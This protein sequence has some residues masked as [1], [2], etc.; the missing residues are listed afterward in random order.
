MQLH[1]FQRN[2]VSNSA[3]FKII[4]AGRRSG[5]STF[6]LEEMCYTAVTGKD[7][8]IFYICPTMVQAR[9]IIWEALKS[10]LGGIGETNEARL[11][12]KVPTTDGGY[13][14]I[15]VSGFESRENFRGLKAHL[16]VFDEL[17]TMRDFFIGWQEIFR[18]ALTDTAGR[19]IFIGTPKKENPNL[20]RLEKIAEVDKDYAFFQFR[21]EDNPFIPKEEIEKARQELDYST[22]RQEFLAEYVENQGSL[23]KYDALVDVFSNTITKE[24]AKYLTVDI[25]DDGTDKT[26]FSFWEGLEEYRRE[27]F[28]RLNTEG[29]IQ[30]IREYAAQE[31]I[32]YSNIAVDA[33]GVGAGVASSSQLDG[34]IG[35]KS[36]FAPIKTDLDPTRLPNVSYLST[37]PLTSDY[38]NLRSQCVFVLADHVNNHKIASKVTGRM[39]EA[40]IEELSTYQDASTGDG[41]RMATMKEDVK[42]I[43]GRS[44]DDSDCF[45]AGTRVTTPKGYKNIEDIKIGDYVT[46]PFG[47]SRVVGTIMKKSD[48]IYQLDNKLVGTGNHRIFS[49]SIFSTLDNYM[50]RVYTYYTNNAYNKI[51]WKILS[52]L[53]TKIKSIGFRVLVDTSITAHTK[54]ELDKKELHCIGRS[55]KILTHLKFL[56]GMMY[57][58][59]TVI[60]LII[61]RTIWL[62]LNLA[63]IIENTLKSIGKTITKKQQIILTK[64]E[65]WLLSG[66]GQKMEENGTQK[67]LKKYGLPCNV[68]LFFALGVVKSISLIEKVVTALIVAAKSLII[69]IKN[70][71][72]LENVS[73]VDMILVSG[74]L[75]IPVIA[76]VN[77]P[78]RVDGVKVYTLSLEEQNVYFANDIL[79]ANCWIMRMYFEVRKKMLPD[80]GQERSQVIDRQI[81]LMR[82]KAQQNKSNK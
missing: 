70:I 32:P 59:L 47:S 38:K 22:F 36:S 26:K 60:L 72:K 3:R 39:K 49:G 74:S 23:F 51:I 1:N 50:M 58:I 34:I 77:V 56:M 66:M 48:N 31:R 55:G 73:L 78:Q 12:M 41:K 67:T 24:N 18:P 35:Y 13:S 6:A 8:N 33:I 64:Q 4:R 44:P 29:I 80:L 81:A 28:E 62:L 5:K 11:E 79:V 69:E 46:T 20:R 10:R 16:I 45:V 27:E 17:D 40:V 57:T 9:Q 15:F 65:K 30:K 37:A 14:K 68:K 43:I 54:T 53:S 21:T 52:L 25:A 61:T 71:T 76:H 63:N 42:A 7:R 2:V 82:A 19:A 75:N